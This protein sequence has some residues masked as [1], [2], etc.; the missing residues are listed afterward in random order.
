MNR[1]QLGAT[2]SKCLRHVQVTL[3]VLLLA[4]S[5]AP[6][7]ALSAEPDWSLGWYGGQFYDSEP[8]GFLQGRA[9]LVDQY[10]F[11]LTASKTVW[12]SAALPLSLEIDGMLGQQFGVQSLN[13]IAV[14]PV[15]RW[16]SFPWKESLQ[17]DVRLGP[18][19]LSYTSMVSPLERG[20]EGKGSRA[21]NFLLLELAFSR[22]SAKSDEVFMRLHHRCAIYD[23]LNNY[24]ANGEDFVTF[25]YRYRF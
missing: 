24:G 8:A 1:S 21:L 7:K 11:A 23:L 13:E 2:K 5:W 17:T 15:L 12:R 25:G 4:F 22:P 3:C 9:N 20:V 19:G 16:S 18:L 10:I 6:S 14:A